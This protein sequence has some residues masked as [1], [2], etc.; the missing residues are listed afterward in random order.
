MISIHKRER[1]VKCENDSRLQDLKKES[2]MISNYH[3]LKI[4]CDKSASDVGN[5]Y[6]FFVF[7]TFP[8]NHL[9]TTWDMTSYRNNTIVLTIVSSRILDCCPSMVLPVNSL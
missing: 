2:R 7:F 6:V 1:K 3:H 5:F 9:G 4:H 8:N